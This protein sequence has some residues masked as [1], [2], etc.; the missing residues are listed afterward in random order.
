MKNNS[1]VADFWGTDN[2]GSAE[3]QLFYLGV[4]DPVL[5]PPYGTYARHSRTH[6][7]DL[8]SNTVQL[9]SNYTVE[10]YHNDSFGLLV[11]QQKVR[12][13]LEALVFTTVGGVY[14]QQLEIN[15]DFQELPPDHVESKIRLFKGVLDFEMI[16]SP[17]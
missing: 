10:I 2:N 16:H 6:E 14:I 13:L 12:I 3:F 4:F 11:L 15:D 5:T 8:H 1:T 17:T 7:M 9:I